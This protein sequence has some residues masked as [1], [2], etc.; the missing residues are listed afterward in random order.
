MPTTVINSVTTPES[1]GKPVVHEDL[2]LLARQLVQGNVMYFANATARDAAFTKL[3]VAPPTG[4]LAHLADVDWYTRRSSTG[5]WVPMPG[6]LLGESVRNTT[7]GTFTSETLI[8]YLTL[9]AVLPNATLKV[10]YETSVQSNVT[11][12]VQ[13]LL[14]WKAGTTADLTGA[15]FATKL[16]SVD[17][18]SRG[19][20]ISST[21]SLPFAAGGNITIVAS[22]LRQSGS[23][24]VQSFGSANQENVLRVNYE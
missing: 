2:A 24:N 10:F 1:T 16:V 13:V 11:D 22:A 18:A 20:L 19:A 17:V 9:Q 5:S 15:Q 14:R 23:G 8:D 6:K 3:G 21:R 4:A 12:I 7:V